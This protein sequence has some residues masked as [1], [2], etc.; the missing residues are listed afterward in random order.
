[1]QNQIFAGAFVASDILR[2]RCEPRFREPD[3]NQLLNRLVDAAIGRVRR[4]LV[5]SMDGS[6]ALEAFGL[7]SC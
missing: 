4:L 5:K 6:D 1:M 2:W 7:D 3:A